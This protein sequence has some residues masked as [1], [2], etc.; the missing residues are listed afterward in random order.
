MDFP[1]SGTGPGRYRRIVVADEDA[2]VVAF[3][4]QTLREDKYA[5][6]H[7]YDALSAVELALA[8]DECHLVITNTRV[9]GPP[10]IE[11]IHELRSRQPKLP[12]LYLANLGRSTPALES[13]LPSDVPILRE[14]FAAEELRAMV[15][16]LLATAEVSN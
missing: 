1:L 15:G 4:I 7:A 14:P 6:F 16:R 2:G 9:G 10:G 11:L 8:L 13:Q 5:V 3:V 12:I